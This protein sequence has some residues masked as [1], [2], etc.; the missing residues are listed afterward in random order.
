MRVQGSRTEPGYAAAVLE[1]LDGPA[2]SNWCAAALTR[3]RRARAEIDALNVY[4]VPDGDTGTNLV[5]TMEAVVTALAAGPTVLSVAAQEIAQAALLGARGNSG[6]ILSQLLRGFADEFGSC[7]TAGPAELRQALRRA[8][9]Q[10]Y[11]AVAEPVEGTILSVARAAAEAAGAA[12]TDTWGLA[13]VAASA[14]RGAAAALERTPEQLPVLAQAG[15]VDAGGR[16]LVVLLEAL[17]AVVSG[18]ES[19][20]VPTGPAAAE[21]GLVQDPEEEA[22]TAAASAAAR[23]GPPS[24]NGGPAFEVQ[25]LLDA[26]ADAIPH[27]KAALLSLGDSVLVVGGDRLW[28]VHAHV[29][30]VGAAIEAGLDAG[31]PH[32]ISV[33]HFESSGRGRPRA[34]AIV[35]VAPGLA[36]ANLF[37]QAGAVVVQ[38]PEGLAPSTAD[39]LGAVR[40]SDSRQVVLLPNGGDIRAVADAAAGL[41]R[42]EGRKVAVI[43]TRSPVQGL[44]AI[45]VHDAQRRF[46]EDVIA[47]S[48]AAAATRWGEVTRAAR[49]SQTPA[50]RCRAGDVLGLIEGSVCLVAPSVGEAARGLLDRLLIGGGE[51][52]TLITG[53][54]ADAV[55]VEQLRSYLA[56]VRPAVEVVVYHG[57]QPHHPLL[58]GVE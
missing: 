24:Q 35:A 38:H 55:L 18:T 11:Q 28:S 3:L 48:S 16:G 47:M 10:A 29:D 1:R 9:E 5:A 53:A 50:G 15:V 39:L 6:V 34:S 14:L 32:R 51:L 40:E 45:A 13:E 4:P 37:R 20:E 36:L 26:Q 22:A 49:E 12:D 31:R 33:T 42:D 19:A 25:Y 7:E 58:V 30:D 21:A 27:L 54:D 17:A 43:P 8:A 56:V 44:A 2:V 46:D 57:G 52:V 23:T 41:A